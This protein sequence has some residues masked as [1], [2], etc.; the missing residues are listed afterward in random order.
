MVKL[1]LAKDNLI[2]T[3]LILQ[4]KIKLHSSK[5][6]NLL[7]VKSTGYFYTLKCSILR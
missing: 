3:E 1:H 2:K 6:K 7:F 5:I 4:V